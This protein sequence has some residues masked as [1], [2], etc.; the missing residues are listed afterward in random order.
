MDGWVYG[1]NEAKARENSEPGQL[2]P[3]ISLLTMWPDQEKCTGVYIKTLLSGKL[4]LNSLISLSLSDNLSLPY[5]TMGAI[6]EQG[7]NGVPIP[8]IVHTF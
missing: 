5:S 1:S 6:W 8:L 3:V 4:Q 2:Q 7:A